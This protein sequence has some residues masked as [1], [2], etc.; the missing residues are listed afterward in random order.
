MPLFGYAYDLVTG[1]IPCFVCP[2]FENGDIVKFYKEKGFPP[3]EDRLTLVDI[4][5]RQSIYQH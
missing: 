2:F 4:P 3:F 1:N 5:A